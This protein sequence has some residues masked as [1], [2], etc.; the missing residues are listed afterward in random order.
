MAAS[1]IAVVGAAIKAT[2]QA[3]RFC[4]GARSLNEELSNLVTELSS[5][6]HNLDNVGRSLQAPETAADVED[7]ERHSGYP[8]V[9]DI[10]ET[11]RNCHGSMDQLHACFARAFPSKPGSKAPWFER[12]LKANKLDHLQGEIGRIRQQIQ[13]Y[14][15]GMQMGLT[16]LNL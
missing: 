1:V 12:G 4:R 11:M 3:L 5:L 6:K 7:L 2:D 16:I 14:L 8:V 9:S 15:I 10:L 13:G